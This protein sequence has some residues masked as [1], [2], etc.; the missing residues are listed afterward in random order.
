MN[1][2]F[3]IISPR[4]F[5]IGAVM[6][7]LLPLKWVL[8][9]ILAAAIHELSHYGAI[10]LCGGKIHGLQIDAGGMVMEMAPLPP[11]RELIC[12]LAGPVGS[13]AMLFFVRQIPMVALC[14]GIQGLFN[15]L[16]VYPLDGGRVLRSG[17]AL[18]LPDSWA[19]RIC[20]WTEKTCLMGMLL[21]GLWGAFRYSLGLLPVLVPILLWMRIRNSQKYV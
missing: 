2:K 21:L 4:V 7:M 11:G 6:V 16:P 9:L 5:L 20:R 19:D 12:A 13:L 15:L 17:A 18:V 1:G 10:R 3:L 14:A 8:S